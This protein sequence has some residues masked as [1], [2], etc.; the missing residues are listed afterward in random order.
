M[1]FALHAMYKGVTPLLSP[2]LISEPFLIND[3]IISKSFF[4]HAKYNL[5]SPNLLTSLC[6]TTSVGLT[7]SICLTT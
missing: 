1:L 4:K 6:L 5:V 2:L 7:T 3:L